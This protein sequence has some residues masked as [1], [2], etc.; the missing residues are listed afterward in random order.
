MGY[1]LSKGDDD[2]DF[3]FTTLPFSFPSPTPGSRTASPS[4]KDDKEMSKRQKVLQAKR[5]NKQGVHA[6]W[7]SDSVALSPCRSVCRL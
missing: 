5:V 2:F 6:V 3:S 1:S 4:R 7:S